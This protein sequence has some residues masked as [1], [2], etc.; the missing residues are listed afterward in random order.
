MNYM[1]KDLPKIERPRERLKKYGARVLSDE[2]LI[3][4]LLRTGTKQISVKDLS[5]EIRKEIN[6][7][8]DLTINSL[9]SIKGIGEVK[10]ITLIAA[11]EFGKRINEIKDDKTIKITKA[12]NIYDYFKDFL[13]N[14]KQENLIVVFLDT[15]NKIICYKRLF[16][17][18]VNMSICHPR[19]VFKEAVKNS[20]VKIILV[21][22]HPS[23]DATPS[24]ADLKFTKQVLKCG[25]MMDIPLLDHIIIGRERYYSFYDSGEMDERNIKE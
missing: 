11:I 23:G 12:E 22:N 24:L 4:I 14:E 15:K 3:A 10:A 19:E 9:Q 18:T 17:G 20:A 8:N 13:K 2:E 1:I 5:I 25:Q 16:I 7:Y 21:H 6:D